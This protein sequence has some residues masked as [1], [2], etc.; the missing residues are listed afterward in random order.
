MGAS[1]S[2]VSDPHAFASE[3]HDKSADSS[4]WKA[5]DYVIVGGGTAGSVLASR[6]SEDPNVSVLLI[7]AGTS[8][9]KAFMTQ[10]P[11]AWP[12][13]LKTAVDW[14]YK[15]VT[16]TRAGN[17]LHTVPRGKVL[18]GSSAINA[19]IYQHCS[20]E[21][22]DEWERMGAVGWGYKD[23]HPYLIK[24]ELFAPHA[25]HSGVVATEHGSGG[26][27]K[28]GYVDAVPIH[29]LFL[30]ASEELGVPRIH[31]FNTSR[32]HIGAS[33]FLSITDKGKRNSTAV[34]Y[35]PPSVLKRPNLT[36]AVTTIV[37][38]ILFDESG[39]EPRAVGVEVSQSATGAKFRVRAV[40]EVILSAGTVASP[41]LLLV[42]GV[43][44]KPAL[45]KL[46]IKV[47][48]D[49]PHV[50]RTTTTCHLSSGPVCIRGKGPG[51]TLDFLNSPV[52]AVLA[53]VKWL[54]FS[55]GPMTGLTAPGAAFIRVDDPKIPPEPS[56]APAAANATGPNTPD[57]EIVW[58][59]LVIGGF[60][61][62]I[63]PGIYG[64]TLGP[65][66]LKPKSSGT[67]T[68]ASQSIYDPPVIDP[69][70]FADDNDMAVLVRGVRFAQ[71][72]GR[73]RA[74][75]GVLEPRADS[76]DPKDLFYMGDADPARITDEEIKDYIRAHC[77]AA[78][79]PTSTARIAASPAEGVV[80]AR[81]RVFG[82]RGLRVVDASV[83]PNQ[84]S[85]HPVAPVVAIAERAVDLIKA[86]A[87]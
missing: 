12:K 82:V 11:L 41:H 69:N 60:D 36:V 47:V 20:P 77:S 10:I 45:E 14:D 39:A 67:I 51:Y 62:Q 43:G 40:R 33:T 53:L 37:E 78:F 8:H 52:Q 29:K 71:R 79:H 7:E 2:Y 81:L 83:F 18:G 15:T 1:H 63:P 66:L 3:V 55:T 70:Y 75:A 21:D 84:I 56:A 57:L 30:N 38:R 59:P 44:D 22:F 31:D 6:L 48:Q 13:L 19:L 26:L 74:F 17:R 4:S 68:L 9:E 80:D 49:L 86:D 5:Y 46:G 27:W 58:F 25:D 73:S 23:L 42:S 28:T 32:G 64:A 54:A 87:A 72:L 16:Q 76:T 50:G 85:G 35:L 61:V 24:S 65:V 34:A